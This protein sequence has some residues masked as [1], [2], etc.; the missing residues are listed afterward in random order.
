MPGQH[1][2]IDG[3]NVMFAIPSLEKLLDEDARKAREELEKLVNLYWRSAQNT[4]ATI[5]YD[6]RSVPDHFDDLRTGDQPAVVYA[7]SLKSADDYI[8][9]Q[10]ENLRSP[11]VTVVSKDKRIISRARKSGCQTME[12]MAFM[13]LIRKNSRGRKGETPSKYDQKNMSENDIQE[14]LDIFGSGKK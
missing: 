14:W 1:Y 13:K 8:I 6:S 5:V 12:P 2:I 9:S 11:S 10:A 4:T 3:Y 7:G